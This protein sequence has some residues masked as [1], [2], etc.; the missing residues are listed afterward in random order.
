M[1]ILKIKLSGIFIILFISTFSFAQ[2]D[3]NDIYFESEIRQGDTGDYG[4]FIKNNIRE[5]FIGYE[6]HNHDGEPGDDYYHVVL[7]ASN[8]PNSKGAFLSET[9]LFAIGTNDPCA[10]TGHDDPNTMFAVNGAAFSTAGSFMGSGSDKKLKKNITRLDESIDKFMK[11]NFYSYEY[12]K[13]GIKRYGILAQEIKDDFPNSI[14][15]FRQDGEEYYAFN[16]NDL[17]YTGLKVV[18]ENSKEIIEQDEQIRT[19]VAENQILK[20][21]LEAERNRNDQQQT[22][23]EAIE[24]ALASQGIDLS[25]TQPAN[26]SIGIQAQ[27]DNPRLEQNTPNPFSY[28]T[29]IAYYLPRNTQTATLVIQDISGK[30]IAKRDLPNQQGVGR[31]Q[32]NVEDAQL[33]KG[34]FTYSLYINQQLIDTKKMLLAK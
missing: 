32:V 10:L 6:F 3:P 11:V 30:T 31:V 25:D 20:A 24:A 22:K 18:Q 7:R 9:G 15:T 13:S 14:S 19:L 29:S 16:P 27:D 12:K 1:K 28:F 5:G 8:S 2:V 26:T 17:I 34:T 4:L 23:L 33:Q 21:E